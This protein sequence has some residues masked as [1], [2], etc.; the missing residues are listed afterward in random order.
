[1]I[2]TT[3]LDAYFK[4]IARQSVIQKEMILNMTFLD[5]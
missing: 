1:M 3:V 5:S 4:N 2:Y